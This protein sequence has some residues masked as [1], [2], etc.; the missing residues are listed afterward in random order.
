[1]RAGSAGCRGVR[2]GLREV[3]PGLGGLAE[4]ILEIDQHD[5][6]LRRF[7]PVQG[8][9]LFV[10]VHGAILPQDAMYRNAS[11]LP[12]SGGC[13]AGCRCWPMRM[14]RMG[15]A[16]DVA[17]RLAAGGAVIVDGGMRSQLQADGAP[18]DEVA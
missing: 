6:Y 3:V 4:V 18:M 9:C 14:V 1:E 8:C 7:Q 13:A 12:S 16:L 10:L 17:G 11:R 2:F 15:G 5:R